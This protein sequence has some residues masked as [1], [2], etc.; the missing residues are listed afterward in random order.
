MGC[1]TFRLSGAI[2][3]FV[4]CL[5]RKAVADSPRWETLWR[6]CSSPG[7]VAPIRSEV[8]LLQHIPCSI[9]HVSRQPSVISGSDASLLCQTRL[10]ISI[11]I[12]W[13]I[14][15]WPGSS[16]R[17]SCRGFYHQ[18]LRWSY[19]TVNQESSRSSAHCSEKTRNGFFGSSSKAYG[20]GMN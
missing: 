7:P 5:R 19:C 4:H 8:Q 14:C 2:H 17:D 6:A 16:V 18:Y 13:R 12:P 15:S 20:D 9:L 10:Q 3:R 1:A 11:A